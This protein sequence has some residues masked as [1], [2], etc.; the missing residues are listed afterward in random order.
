ML[1]LAKP[2]SS[3]RCTPWQRYPTGTDS[4]SKSDMPMSLILRYLFMRISGK[5]KS[6]LAQDTHDCVRHSITCEI[7]RLSC[8]RKRYNAVPYAVC[9]VRNRLTRIRSLFYF[10]SLIQLCNLLALFTFD[11]LAV[12]LPIEFSAIQVPFA[13]PSHSGSWLHQ[14]RLS[15]HHDHKTQ[16]RNASL[17]CLPA[18]NVITCAN[19]C[20]WNLCLKAGRSPS[21]HW[22]QAPCM[23]RCTVG[24]RPLPTT[25]SPPFWLLTSQ[26]FIF[27]N[28][29]LVIFIAIYVLQDAEVMTTHPEDTRTNFPR[30]M[31][32]GQAIQLIEDHTQASFRPFPMSDPDS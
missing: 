26:S 32:W 24:R 21:G 30:D 10:L 15:P 20:S 5:M 1:L 27:E 6:M 19:V 8:L 23:L 7:R 2:T 11:S 14:R 12:R 22:T 29:D 9:S 13:T 31:Q 25:R 17:L 28:Q 18:Y 4:N 16:H 3:R